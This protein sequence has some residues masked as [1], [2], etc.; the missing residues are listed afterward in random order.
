MRG[1][2]KRA[3]WV[4]R[5]GAGLL[6]AA[7]S[8]RGQT[9]PPS[10][11]LPLLTNIS[12]LRR[13]TTNDPGR[14][15]RIQGTVTC[16]LPKQNSFVI[17]ESGAGLYLLNAE[18]P[19]SPLPLPGYR[20]EVEGLARLGVARVS[21]ITPLGQ[22]PLPAPERPSW[23]QLMNGSLDCCYVD[24]L[25]VVESISSPRS[26]G[27]SRVSFR[28][29]DGILRLDLRRDGIRP[30]PL[31]DCLNAVIRLRGCWFTARDIASSRLKVGQ[32][33]MSD[34]EIY[35]EQPAPEN[36]FAL[37]L[38]RAGD[39]T[40]FNPDLSA[41]RRVRVQGTIVFSRW[42]DYFLMDGEDGLR[43]L[44]QEPLGLRAGDRVEVVGFPQLSAAAPVLR[45]A[46][47]RKLGAAP[48]P[49]PRPL[50]PSELNEPRHDSTRVSIEGTLA[51]LRHKPDSQ[52]LEMQADNW[53]FIARLAAPPEAV[54]SL[55]IGSRLK[56]TGVYCAQGGYEALGSDV[57]PIDL[58][59]STPADIQVLST[60]PWWT[61]ER[62]LVLVGLLSA[63]VGA[64]ALWVTQL[65]R[66]V[67]LRTG[68]LRAEI[69]GRQEAELLRTMEAERSRIARD[70]HD[71]LGS[72]I[73]EIGMLASRA[74]SLAGTE[75][76][77]C[78]YLE[79]M[80]SKTR[81][82]VD[83]LEGI[84]WAMN[85]AHDSLASVISY[86]SF[87][88]DR[89]LALANIRCQ[90]DSDASLPGAAPALSARVRHNLFLAFKEALANIVRHSGAT[91]AAIEA[92]FEAGRLRLKVSDNGRGLATPPS[93]A[94]HDGLANM[95]RRIEA[96]GG[97]FTL[98]SAPGTGTSLVF[99][100]PLPQAL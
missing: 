78:R 47:V 3:G 1:V 29:P 11:A 23:D 64:M 4:P 41:M 73:T 88:A 31:E 56:L 92:R 58:L 81:G 15:F 21:R 65:R 86:F 5:L 34:V 12:E 17:Q 100:I 52:T 32:G 39:L 55:Q 85:P 91:Q 50:S 22:S 46:L 62:L 93:G 60:P 48:L 95:R 6:L 94:G 75:A 69:Q 26:N 37:P 97:E 82:M 30:R 59:L 80:E 96:I 2:V 67:E 77:R 38:L 89:F 19:A 16:S 33:R 87:Y 83:A 28:T 54:R 45:G 84:V 24:L 25:G 42:T 98:S 57:A 10:P 53:R 74:R 66:R 71:D 61:L 72:D 36:P 90:F 13:L 40:R 27:W 70:L 9:A 43:F 35:I 51:Q 49:A 14:E 63:L 7:A 20:L 44:A 76:E 68:E 79:Q 99:Q 8:L 18:P